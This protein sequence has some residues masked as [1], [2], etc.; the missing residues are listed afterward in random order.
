MKKICNICNIEKDINSFEW[1]KDR[2]NPRKTCKLCRSRNIKHSEKS[3]QNKK[4]YK[5]RYRESGKAAIVWERHKYGI[6]KE[7]IS[8][9]ECL[10]CGSTSN[11][12]IDHC[13]EKNKFRGLLCGNCN[14]ALGM[15]KDNVEVMRKAI[16]YIEYF[17]NPNNEG[18]KDYPHTELKSGG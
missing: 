17:K 1:Q 9:R 18:F 16:K 7:D 5:K 15:F 14:T 6:S 13:H 12:H 3:K 10:L 2:P 4:D 11:L 8:Y